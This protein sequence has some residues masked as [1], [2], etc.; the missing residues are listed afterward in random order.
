M[1]YK[2]TWIALAFFIGL[3]FYQFNFKPTLADKYLRYHPSSFFQTVS[4]NLDQPYEHYLNTVKAA[5]IAARQ[6][7]GVDSSPQTITN[8]LPALLLPKSAACTK[9]QDGKY[10]KGIVLIHGLLDSPYGMTQ[11]ANVFLANCFAVNVVLLPGHGTIPADLLTV[12]YQDWIKAID[13]NVAKLQEKADQ[14]YVGGYSLGGLLTINQALDHPHAF[15]AVILFAPALNVKTALAP[16]ITPIYWLGKLLPALKWWEFRADTSTTRYESIP[17]NPVYQTQQLISLVQEKLKHKTLTIPL[18][19]VQSA[20][21][22]TINANDTKAFFS[23]TTNSKS[24]LIWYTQHADKIDDKRAQIQ[25]SPIAKERILSLSHLSL[26][27]PASDK[28]Y[29]LQGAY[30]DCLYYPEDSLAWRQCEAGFNTYLGETTPDNLA[31]HVIQRI[32]FNPFYTDMIL[33]LNHFL[34]N[35]S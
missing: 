14:L 28:I 5:V 34:Q 20:E 19:V 35:Q 29:G 4:Y 2:K 32:T 23:N 9:S 27:L 12:T 7:A 25:T 33:Q 24:T 13:F 8:N 26:I 18:F 1:T 21:D 17:V 31:G 6:K 30:K 16:L 22:Q 15:K 3:I 10:S 11:L